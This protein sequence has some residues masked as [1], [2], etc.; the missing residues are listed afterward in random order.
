MVLSVVFSIFGDG[1][2][3]RDNTITKNR[4]N[5]RQYHHQKKRKR[6]TIPSPKIEKTTDKTV[7]N[8]DITTQNYHRKGAL[9]GN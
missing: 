1:I 8:I 4:E 3:C 7:V 6:Q 5:D 9:K 2:V